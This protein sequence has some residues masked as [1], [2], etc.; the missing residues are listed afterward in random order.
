LVRPVTCQEQTLKALLAQLRGAKGPRLAST[1]GLGV[2]GW[3]TLESLSTYRGTRNMNP[4]EHPDDSGRAKVFISY[5]HDTPEHKGRVFQFVETLR[6]LGLDAMFDQYK[7]RVSD[8]QAWIRE[9]INQSD[10]VIAICTD[11]YKRR[12]ERTGLA[13]IGTGVSFEG[14]L[15]D[16]AIYENRTL[17]G[18]KFL[19]VVFEGD[20]EQAIP[21][22]LRA[23]L[24][25]A[26]DP[27]EIVAPEDAAEDRIGSYEALMRAIL[28]RPEAEPS[29][30]GALPPLR[31]RSGRNL[32]PQPIV[33]VPMEATDQYSPQA[34]AF[35]SRSVRIRDE[36]D[37]RLKGAKLSIDV[38][39][40]GLRAF[41]E[42][43]LMSFRLWVER[44]VRL[45]ILVLDVWSDEG[46]MLADLQDRAE[47]VEAGSIRHDVTSFVHAT[48]KMI[49]GQPD[50]QVRLSNYHPSINI[51]RIDDEI[52]W[53]P[54][55][56]GDVSR[57]HP[58]FIISADNSLFAPLASHFDSLWRQSR[59]IDSNATM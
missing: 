56:A 58:T 50:L 17:R 5:S 35:L 30:L 46:A 29:P 25:F 33:Q 37:K 9:Q 57:N 53:G 4:S 18:T 36:Y 22:F 48:S 39:G 32:A 8:L 45:R 28:G 31:Q 38:L 44:G 15:I 27:D 21:D 13:S 40:W 47:G 51:F 42:D 55:L 59:P 34:Q 49:D 10:F 19:P 26:I 3:I 2:K 16:R 41:R 52:I 12:A 1:E 14:G 20:S 11:E 6:S 54:Y 7:V 43:Y 24:H 23:S